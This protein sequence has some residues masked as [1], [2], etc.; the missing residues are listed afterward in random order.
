MCATCLT[1]FQKSVLL[2]D[3]RSDPLA[4]IFDNDLGGILDCPPG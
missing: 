2:G 3:E 1:T 4:Q